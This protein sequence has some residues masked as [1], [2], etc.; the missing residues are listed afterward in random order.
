MKKSWKELWE[1]ATD[2]VAKPKKSRERAYTWEEIAAMSGEVPD[3]K[4]SRSERSRAYA[5][6]IHPNMPTWNDGRPREVQE[7][8]QT[9]IIVKPP[10]GNAEPNIRVYV[11]NTKNEMMRKRQ[12]WWTEQMS[13]Q[14]VCNRCRREKELTIDHIIPQS[15]LAQ[16]G[17]DVEKMWDEQNLQ[18]LCRYCNTFKGNKLDFADKKTKPLIQKY[19]ALIEDPK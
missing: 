1:S 19:L 17:F 16:M 11:F 4:P 2:F 12:A 13:Y 18:I 14:T 15:L 7:I 3:K 8:N 5:E 9:P 6:I 10:V